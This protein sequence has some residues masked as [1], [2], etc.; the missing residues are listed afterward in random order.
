MMNQSPVVAPVPAWVRCS[1]FLSSRTVTS[2]DTAAEAFWPQKVWGG[3]GPEKGMATHEV[4]MQHGRG[5]HTS[6]AVRFGLTRD[7]RH[8]TTHTD[9]HPH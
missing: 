4:G 1:K 2:A 7:C 3:D 8:G 6:C 9:R 5:Q